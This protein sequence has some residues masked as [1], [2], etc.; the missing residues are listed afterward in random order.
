M[1]TGSFQWG[2]GGMPEH[3]SY[4]QQTRQRANLYCYFS[5]LNKRNNQGFVCKTTFF[6]ATYTV[7]NIEHSDNQLCLCSLLLVTSPKPG[8]ISR[9][10]FCTIPSSGSWSI[11]FACW[12]LAPKR[13]SFWVNYIV[14]DEKI[15]TQCRLSQCH[16]FFCKIIWRF[17]V[18]LLLFKK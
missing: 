12:H 3:S 5:L 14:V 4:L 9:Y 2:D 6:I 13:N 17:Q 8:R 11:H 1:V 15:I 16:I 10:K 18:R 7:S